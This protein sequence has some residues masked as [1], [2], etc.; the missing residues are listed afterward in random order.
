MTTPICQQCVE[1]S[2]YMDYYENPDKKHIIEKCLRCE[3]ELR[4]VYTYTSDQ[5][6]K[7]AILKIFHE[8]TRL[9]LTFKTKYP[10]IMLQILNM[11]PLTPTQITTA[12]RDGLAM[13][14]K[15]QQLETL[16]HDYRMNPSKTTPRQILNVLIAYFIILKQLT[17]LVL[18]RVKDYKNISRNDRILLKMIFIKMN[19]IK[20]CA[21]DGKNINLNNASCRVISNK[22]SSR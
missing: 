17:V 12:L 13:C 14:P 11:E 21:G 9:L 5:Q 16:L 20:I 1:Q 6:R 18:Q 8:I 3:L 4:D 22:T 7:A 10:A 2:K 19:N 15:C